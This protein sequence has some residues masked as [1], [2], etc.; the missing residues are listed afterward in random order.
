[1]SNINRTALVSAAAAPLVL[2]A[3]ALAQD[4]PVRTVAEIAD[5]I[6]RA[7]NNNHGTVFMVTDDGIVLADPINPDFA[8]WLKGEL[9]SRFG[10]PVRYVVYSHHHW[11][12]ASGGAAFADSAQF[13]GHANM[14]NHLAL[15]PDSTQLTD[16]EG[17]YAPLAALDTDADGV[18]SRAEAADMDAPRFAGLDANGD[19]VISGAELMRGPVSLVHPPNITYTDQIEISLGGK[20][21]R[22]NWVGEMNHSLDSSRISFPDASVMFVVDY[23]TFQ[24][25]PFMEMDF[26]NAMYEEWMA[27]IRETE[28]IARDFDHVAT[29]HGPVGTVDDITDWRLY[30]EALEAAVAAAIDAG[31]SLEEMRQS[32]EIPDYS[33]WN[34][35]NWLDM[36][37]LGMY[38]FLTD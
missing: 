10:V 5:G 28:E 13:V 24:R 2:A 21:V 7:T 18:I 1:M 19:E 22:M 14:L 6:Y 16:V 36:N 20:R 8:N 3:G 26:E 17:Q 29:G 25:L 27:A 15:P 23:I 38:H 34:G 30:F 9:D 12:H 11:D 4:G 35:Y 37:V 31:Q 33:H 32:I